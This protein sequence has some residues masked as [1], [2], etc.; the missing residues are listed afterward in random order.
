M[1][2]NLVRLSP[3]LYGVQTDDGTP[4]CYIREVMA[5]TGIIVRQ[6]YAYGKPRHG[7]VPILSSFPAAPAF[8]DEARL[9]EVPL[10]DVVQSCLQFADYLLE[11]KAKL[12]PPDDPR[13]YR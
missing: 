11:E 13:I 4:L 6:V 10:E 1:T 12:R 3:G 8:L 5:S 2:R 7:G 9:R